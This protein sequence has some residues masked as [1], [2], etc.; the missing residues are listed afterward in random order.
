LDSEELTAE[1]NNGRKFS[2][3]GHW[4]TAARGAANIKR[5]EAVQRLNAMGVKVSPGT[6]ARWENGVRLPPRTKIDA[7]ADAL[8]VSRNAARRKAGY[9][10]MLKARKKKR[11]TGV[12][13]MMLHE[14]SNDAGSGSRILRLYSLIQAYFE[15]REPIT[16]LQ[17]MQQIAEVFDS[18]DG[19]S[20]EQRTEAWER[21]KQ[22]LAEA[23]NLPVMSD[24]P[25]N[26]KMII[27]KGLWPSVF[28]GTHVHVTIEYRDAGERVMWYGYVVR[29][30]KEK[31]NKTVAMLEC[32]GVSRE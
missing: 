1:E 7:L 29:D 31:M 20:Y 5:G 32:T 8:G 6:W 26:A 30:L 14:L 27:P 17:R 9:T 3:F 23:R 24:A 13:G 4:L 15:K 22:V 16:N 2:T 10:V 11:R 19:L 28:R 21:V 25:E 12:L 18:L